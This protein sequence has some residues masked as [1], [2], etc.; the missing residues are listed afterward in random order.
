MVDE[1]RAKSYDVV[2]SLDELLPPA[3]PLRGPSPDDVSDSAVAQVAVET[4][5]Q[6]LYRS[7]DLEAEPLLR[8]VAGLQERL[9]IRAERVEQMER[10]IR[11]LERQLADARHV[12]HDERSRPL[13]T[14]LRRQAGL[15]KRRVLRQP[16]P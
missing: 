14:H 8:Q 13:K 9:R 7:H 11:T 4:I 6:L 15:L 10:R 5:S 12:L 2:G 16:L 1:I 3:E